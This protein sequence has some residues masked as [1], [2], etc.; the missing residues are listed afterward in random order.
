MR[1][2]F[3]YTIVELLTVIAIS[4]ILLTLIV[5]PLFQGFNLTRQAQSYVEAQAQAKSLITRIETE[6]G[7]A[8]AIRDNSGPKGSCT[9]V[10]PNRVGGSSVIDLPYTKLDMIM[11]AQGKPSAAGGFTDPDSGIIDPTLKSPRGDIRTPVA[12]GSTVVRYF[13][14]LMRP[15]QG[16]APLLYNNPFEGSIMQANGAQENLY[17]VRRAEVAAYVYRL[18]DPSAPASAT[19]KMGYYGNTDFFDVDLATGQI[20]DFDSPAFFQMIPSTDYNTGTLVATAAGVQKSGRITNWIKASIVVS[21]G[22][23]SDAIGV[24]FNPASKEVRYDGNDPRLFPMI[25]FRPARTPGETATPMQAARLGEEADYPASSN[26]STPRIAPDVYQTKQPGWVDQLV[27]VFP[28][29]YQQNIPSANKYLVVRTDTATPG[30]SSFYYDP[31]GGPELSTGIELFDVTT[32]DKAR[33]SGLSYP[34]SRAL[35]AA[36]SRSNWLSSASFATLASAFV[37]MTQ[38]SRLG[39]I[40]ASFPITEFGEPTKTPA[41]NNPNS[42]PEADSGPAQTPSQNLGTGAPYSPKSVV[43]GFYEVNTCFN[44]VYNEHT[45]LRADAHRFIDLRVAPI[46]YSDNSVGYGPLDPTLGFKRLSIVPG[47]EEVYG[48]DQNPGANF[49]NLVRYHRTG[50][51]PGVNQYKI[52]YTDQSEPTNAGGAIDY[53]LLD[54]NPADLAG[55]NPAVYDPTNFVSAVVQPRYKAGYIQLNS[56]PNNPIPVLTGGLAGQ[57]AFQIYYRVQ[58]TK[59]GDVLTVDYGTRAGIQ[60]AV[61]VRKYPGGTISYPQSVTLSSQAA[62]R[63]YLR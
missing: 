20:Q 34:F 57:P 47:S 31:A 52:N 55:F 40:T 19:N 15:V 18:R 24:V 10:V 11:P 13:I 62:V 63:N 22:T 17:V 9:V 16:S 1:K 12:P 35:Q 8:V 54:L 36:N 49:G 51:K 14:G 59:G 30:Y 41:A 60:I 32:Y 3:A 21:P 23:R 4:A 56:D 44:R 50:V 42:L 53:S 43:T 48:P 5:V 33:A 27:R 39:R 26:A 37:P 45:E 29:G 2:R 38:D 46:V 7:K 25:Q 61:T 28:E 58:S 6:L